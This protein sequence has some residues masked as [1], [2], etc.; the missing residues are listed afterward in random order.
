MSEK[1]KQ[2]EDKFDELLN[3]VN[4]LT[5]A[6]SEFRE[7]FEPEGVDFDQINQMLYDMTGEIDDQ[8]VEENFE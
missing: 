7:F 4:I 5:E 6:M 1:L 8:L 2:A 3:A